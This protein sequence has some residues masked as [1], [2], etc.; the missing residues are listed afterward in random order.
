MWNVFYHGV[1][2]F[3]RAEIIAGGFVIEGIT[4]DPPLCTITYITRADLKGKNHYKKIF[5]S[6]LNVLQTPD[7][8]QS[9]SV[10]LFS[11][12]SVYHC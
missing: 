12:S 2:L 9:V 3:N 11:C 6:L 5:H 4:E 10:L 7:Y 8:A 1:Y